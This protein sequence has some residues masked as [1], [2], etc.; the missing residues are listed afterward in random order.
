MLI[1]IEGVDLPGLGYA[2]SPDSP[3]GYY[4]VHVAVQ[5]RNVTGLVRVL[6]LIIERDRVALRTTSGEVQHVPDGLDDRTGELA[7]DEQWGADGV[8]RPKIDPDRLG[9]QKLRLMARA[10]AA[11]DGSSGFAVVFWVGRAVALPHWS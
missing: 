10:A 4:N 8:A 6:R 7:G 1:Q 2:P 5:R 3:G 9:D 11:D